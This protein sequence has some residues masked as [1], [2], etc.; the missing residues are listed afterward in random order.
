[1]TARKT[2][3]A[4]ETCGGGLSLL[5]PITYKLLGR[6]CTNH[7]PKII[8]GGVLKHIRHESAE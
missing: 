6:F 3:A 1:M 8:V 7:T 5:D 2:A 4:S